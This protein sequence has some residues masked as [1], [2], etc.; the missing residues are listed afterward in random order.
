MIA[1]ML[2]KGPKGITFSLSEN[3]MSS[4]T[5]KAIKVA[6]K[7]VQIDIGN[8]ITKPK[9]NINL[10]SPPPRDSFLKALSPKILMA[11]IAK[12]APTPE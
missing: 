2:K 8:P 5:G 3:R 1:A 6:K 11:Y 12:K 7:M 4:A 10:M 9:R